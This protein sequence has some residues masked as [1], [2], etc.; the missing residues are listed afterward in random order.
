M[1]HV[2]AVIHPSSVEHQFEISNTHKER[3]MKTTPRAQPRKR[4]ITDAVVSAEARYR[5]ARRKISTLAAEIGR[6]RYQSVCCEHDARI[7]RAVE[8]YIDILEMD[9][10]R[11]HKE[12]EILESNYESSKAI[13]QQKIQTKLILHEG[14]FQLLSGFAGEVS[15]SGSGFSSNVDEH[16]KV[17]LLPML[18]LGSETTRGIKQ[19]IADFAGVPTGAAL[20]DLRASFVS[21]AKRSSARSIAGSEIP[22]IPLP[23]TTRRDLIKQ[24][25]PQDE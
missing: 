9:M 24:A 19:L 18:N 12:L 14:F 2:T 7:R 4:P 23:Q 25:L 22:R 17:C 21:L 13:I 15:N 5:K 20:G 11:H 3:K 6:L 16:K 1:L 10:K 8:P